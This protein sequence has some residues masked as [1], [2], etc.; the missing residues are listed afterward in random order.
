MI[1][2]GNWC[3]VFSLMFRIEILTIVLVHC[4]QILEFLSFGTYWL[5]LCGLAYDQFSWVFLAHLRKWCC[6][7][8][9][10]AELNHVFHNKLCYLYL[11]GAS[12]ILAWLITDWEI[13]HFCM[14]S[15]TSSAI[16]PLWGGCYVI[17]WKCIHNCL[18]QS[19][20]CCPHHCALC[21]HPMLCRA[22]FCD[23]VLL[24]PPPLL[25]QFL[26]QL[27]H[28][29]YSFLLL[30]ARLSLLT[31]GREVLSMAWWDPIT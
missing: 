3:R 10:G 16:L 4:N 20:W 31:L 11:F 1:L 12:R 24:L 30:C 14:F 5:F 6:L 25:S 9:Q 19:H 15:L 22:S 8:F 21:T 26:H 27:W 23:A 28:N 7:C 17:W 18:T 29:G 13:F 2:A